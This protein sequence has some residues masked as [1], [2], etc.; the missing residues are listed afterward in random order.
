MH[1]TGALGVARPQV[2]AVQPMPSSHIAVPSSSIAP[3][4]SLSRP[5]QTSVG[6]I[7]GP[8]QP[9]A[10]Q[11]RRPPTHV[12][13]GWNCP[14]VHCAGTQPKPMAAAVGASG[15]TAIAVRPGRREGARLLRR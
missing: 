1:V 10:V 13:L 11:D 5:S 15:V 2:S 3:S 12:V 9:S 14:M 7:H 8:Q 6:L 4:Q